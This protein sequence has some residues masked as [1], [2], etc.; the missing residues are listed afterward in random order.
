M[1]GG[2]FGTQRWSGKAAYTFALSQMRHAG[3]IASP[4]EALAERA[5]LSTQAER[6]SLDWPGLRYMRR[7]GRAALM[8]ERTP[9]ATCVGFDALAQAFHA[10]AVHQ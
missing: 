8:A 3:R 9:V 1:I 7:N 2:R 4:D 5:K 6:L 10:R